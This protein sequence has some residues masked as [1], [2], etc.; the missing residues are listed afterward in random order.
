MLWWPS[1]RRSTFASEDEAT[2]ELR[3]ARPFGSSFGGASLGV[4]QTL[5]PE[6]LA[7]RAVLTLRLS[8]RVPA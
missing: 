7:W 1:P 3:T 2:I 5:A 8:L 6:S 4:C